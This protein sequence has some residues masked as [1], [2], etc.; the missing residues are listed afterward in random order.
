MVTLSNRDAPACVPVLDSWG[1]RNATATWFFA[2]RP[3]V[4]GDSAG[5][6]GVA[7]TVRRALTACPDFL[8]VQEVEVDGEH[9]SLEP[10]R[11]QAGEGIDAFENR[12]PAAIERV[13]F[14]VRSVVAEV[15][16][17][18][19]VRLDALADPRRCWVPRT[20]ELE[21]THD[22]EGLTLAFSLHVLLFCDETVLGEEHRPLHRRNAPLLEGAL[23]RIERNVGPIAEWE[24][25][26]PVA[27]YGFHSGTSEG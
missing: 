5:N 3:A 1:Y 4:E 24:G 17:F 18:V 13:P 12:V 16:L 19:W 9:R 6:A 7:D 21:L 23:R 22:A 26:P 14:A 2:S 10:I 8:R 15:D 27:R 20:A 25:W 11:P